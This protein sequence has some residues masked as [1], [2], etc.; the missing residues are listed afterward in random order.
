LVR[1]FGLK[2]KI[3][4]LFCIKVYVTRFLILKVAKQFILKAVFLQM[5]FYFYRLILGEHSELI[6]DGTGANKSD[7]GGKGIY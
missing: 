7:A 1:D 4:H 2:R 6:A 5:N 3:L